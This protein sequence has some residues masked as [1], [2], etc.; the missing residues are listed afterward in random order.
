[1]TMTSED[2]IA[3]LGPVD[4][5]LIADVLATGANQTE[6]AEAFAWVS[7]DEAL[8]SERRPLPTGRIALLIDLLVSDDE[9]LD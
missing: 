7:S 8:M 1:M 5:T 6:L 3:I 2:V 4:E 9:E